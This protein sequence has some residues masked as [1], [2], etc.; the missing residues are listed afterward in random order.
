MRWINRGPDPGHVEAYAREY[1]PRWVSYFRDRVGA[2]PTDSFW[3]EFR[4]QLGELSEYVCWYCE[5]RCDRA[6]EVGGRAATLDHF[7]PLSRFPNLAY[8]WSNWVFSCHRCNVEN[9]QDRWPENGYVDPA[10]SDE[11]ERPEN[12]FAYDMRTHDVIPRDDLG[13]D[14]RRRAWDTIEDLGLNK[15]DV[16]FYRQHWM[17]RLIEDLRKLPIEEHPPLAK[18]LASY[19]EFLGTTRMVLAQIREAGELP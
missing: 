2:R 7:R 11:K 14:D 8:D 9:K 17:R 10:A 5:R 16:R 12:Y 1:T 18:H 15:V 19:P 4:T 3:R 6:S 13:E